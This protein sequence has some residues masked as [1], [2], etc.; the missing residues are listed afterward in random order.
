MTFDFFCD[1]Q[2]SLVSVHR[3]SFSRKQNKT[4]CGVTV[5]F[6]FT[7]DIM[8]SLLND[9]TWKASSFSSVF[10]FLILILKCTLLHPNVHWLIQWSSLVQRSRDCALAA[11]WCCVAAARAL[12]R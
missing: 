7:P 4:Q 5:V 9:D 2:H 8:T 6:V 12:N 1:V 10:S 3:K 11:Y